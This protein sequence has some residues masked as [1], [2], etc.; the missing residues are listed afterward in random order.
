MHLAVILAA[1]LAVCV[2]AAEDG[3]GAQE[4]RLRA[5]YDDP[6]LA[7]PPPGPQHN[8]MERFADALEA[9][10]LKGFEGTLAPGSRVQ[11]G[12]HW[13]FDDDRVKVTD[14]GVVIEPAVRVVRD[15]K[16]F[17]YFI[18]F[19]DI[20]YSIASPSQQK[21]PGQWRVRWPSAYSNRCR[22]GNGTFDIVLVREVYNKING[23][24]V[25]RLD[26]RSSGQPS[27]EMVCCNGFLTLLC[28]ELILCIF[29]FFHRSRIWTGRLCSQ[30]TCRRTGLC[31]TGQW[32]SSNSSSQQHSTALK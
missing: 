26:W 4:F 24:A 28:V 32:T 16:G 7:T 5:Q 3:D 15:W 25:P 9:A 23:H 22:F 20:S 18:F 30:T 10:L 21:A 12:P 19:S 2:C 27:P 13:R 14:I 11:R 1:S 6:R 17:F 8:N 29:L 31:A